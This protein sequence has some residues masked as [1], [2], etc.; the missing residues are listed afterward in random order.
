MGHLNVASLKKLKQGV[1][2]GVQFKDSEAE[3]CVVCATGKQ[4]RLPFP[5]DG[6]RADEILELVHTDICG[7]MEE[8]SLAGSRYYLTFV[9]DKSRRVFVYFLKTKSEAEVLQAFDDFLEQAERQ[10]GRK[11]KTLRSDNGKEYVNRGFQKRLRE[12]GIRHQ[13]STEYT[14][15]QNGLAERINRTLVE[16]ARCLLFEAKL[17]KSFWAE[18]V[19]TAAYLVNRSPTKGHD[20]TPE[21]AWTKRKPN[22]SHVRVF[23]AK[24]MAHVP[25]QQRRKWDPKSR[26]AIL[27]GF[28][29]LTKAYRLYDPSKKSVFNCRDVIIISEPGDVTTAQE[30]L[31]SNE[32]QQRVRTFV[33]LEFEEP[34]NIE[35][36]NNRATV[37]EPNPVQL[38]DDMESD[39][40]STSDDDDFYSQTETSAA[41]LS[42]E[43]GDVTILALP[44][45][46]S[47]YPPESQV[48]RR[49]GRERA[50]PG[51]YKDF[52]VPSKYCLHEFSPRSSSVQPSLQ[53]GVNEGQPGTSGTQQGLK[54][55]KAFPEKMC[56]PRTRV[57][58]LRSTNAAMWQT[59]MDEEFQS[60]IHN[61][62]WELCDLPPG[63]K[64]I[65]CKWLFKAKDDKKGSIVRYKARIVAQGFTQ[66]FGTDYD[67]VFAPVA[68]Q[69]TFR[70]L[71][72]VASRRNSIVRHVDVKTA[73]LNGELQETIFMRQPEGY[74]SGNERT[75]CR[76]R[77]SLYGLKQSARVWNK[78]VDSVFKRMGFLPAKSDPC[79][80]LRKNR[81]G[82]FAYILI[83]VDDMVVVT[84]SKEEFEAVF[85]GIQKQFTITNLGDIRHFLGMEVKRSESGFQLNQSAYIRK[86]AKWFNLENAKPSK[87]PLDPGYVQQKEEHDQQLLPSNNQFLS[88]I[89][90]VQYIAVHTRP[91]VAVSVLILAKK[92]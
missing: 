46:T 16:R 57:E 51:K 45:Q 42:D 77:R 35:T 55:T 79:L 59:A 62:T 14:P 91:D 15:E 58:A 19:A 33:G 10:T 66:K 60:L 40:E 61:G 32:Q 12:R 90:G 68:K 39:D 65:G 69:E 85:D 38:P 89:G 8:A 84:Q 30:P 49:S 6:H 52:L 50:A 13:T 36:A 81:N 24:V 71:L 41:E 76:L 17:P 11:L 3:N 74:H 25:K 47:S 20:L 75:V 5:K 48:L 78:K 70:T 92:F 37:V 21:E 88:L 31:S 4:S 7:P 44:P 22:L 1:V 54:A 83:Y 23:G 34:I 29:E 67:E 2:S 73:Y 9:D 63:K 72:T 82:E 18:A 43:P 80:Y 26:E 28:S 64:A 86:L 53:V 87:V 56:D 27:V